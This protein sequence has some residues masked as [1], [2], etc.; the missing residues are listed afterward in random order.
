[1]KV[2]V[3]VNEKHIEKIRNE[4]ASSRYSNVSEDLKTDIGYWEDK[5]IK[6]ELMTL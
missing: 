5:Q 3:K 6:I 2:K 4:R 1:M